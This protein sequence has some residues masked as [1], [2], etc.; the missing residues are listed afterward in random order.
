MGE[1]AQW[2]Y[3]IVPS[4]PEMVGDPT[5]QEVEVVAAHVAHLVRLHERG[6]LILAGRTQ[7][8]EGTFGVVIF[9]AT[10]RV[11]AEAIMYGDPGVSTGVFVA[12]LHPF[13]IAAARGEVAD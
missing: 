4:R 6:V 10:D 5:E 12:T 13:G 1:T 11:A 8:Q 2:L 9:E 7:E 3:R